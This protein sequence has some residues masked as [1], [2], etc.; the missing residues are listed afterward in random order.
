MARTLG[1]VAAYR[2]RT[3]WTK[4]TCTWE[5]C[6]KPVKS[7]RLWCGDACVEEYR[8]RNDPGFARD[9]VADRDKGKCESCGL[10]TEPIRVRLR[11]FRDALQEAERR[12]RNLLW[13]RPLGLPGRP[14]P[15]PGASERARLLNVTRTAREAFRVA[16]AAEGFH[17]PDPHPNT[18]IPHLWEMDH[19]IP[20]VEGGG[21][22]DLG[23]LRSLCRA[24]HRRETAAQREGP[25]HGRGSSPWSGSPDG[26]G[27]GSRGSAIRLDAGGSRG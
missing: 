25:G 6:R 5:P 1:G 2:K 9:R 13:R 26:R 7:P 14:A 15:D 12:Y 23:N 21:A 24:C 17:V 18:P 4:G 22:C 20:V 16:L 19:R 27:E 11:A 3:G 8:V 10:D